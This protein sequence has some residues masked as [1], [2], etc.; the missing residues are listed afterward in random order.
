MRGHLFRRWPPVGAARPKSVRRSA[1]GAARSTST[2]GTLVPA[3][4]LVTK[5]RD[6]VRVTVASKLGRAVYFGY[7]NVYPCDNLALCQAK[8]LAFAFVLKRNSARR[9]KGLVWLKT[10]GHRKCCASSCRRSPTNIKAACK[11]ICSLHRQQESHVNQL[12]EKRYE[13]IQFFGNVRWCRWAG[14]RP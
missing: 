9:F 4:L 3:R 10:G 14:A 11:R 6:L 5:R 1:S 7:T 13:P 12:R 8:T 2:R